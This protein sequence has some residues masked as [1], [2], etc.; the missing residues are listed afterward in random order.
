MRLPHSLRYGCVRITHV[1]IT[2]VGLTHSYAVGTRLTHL[3]YHCEAH[4]YIVS[5]RLAHT[6]VTTMRLT[7]L[8]YMHV[9]LTHIYIR[10][11]GLLTR[12]LR[13]THSY[14]TGVRLTFT[15]WVWGSLV[16][17][18][19]LEVHSIFHPECEAHSDLCYNSYCEGHS[20]TMGVRH[21]CEC[22]TLELPLWGSV[23]ITLQVWGSLTFTLGLCEYIGQST[24]QNRVVISGKVFDYYICMTI[25]NG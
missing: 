7:Q 22:D 18:Q 13:L 23:T 14:A 25:I 15:L 17:E 1:Y 19:P 10:S 12:E 3:N 9:G 20:Y 4:S 24:L 2:S 21:I 5:V 11:V 6:W 16:P 8:H